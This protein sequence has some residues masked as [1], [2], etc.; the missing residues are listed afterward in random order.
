MRDP[1]VLAEVKETLALLVAK[2]PG[3]GV[4]VRVPPYAAVQCVG[5]PT[6]RRGT[7]P[8]VVEMDADTWLAL[9]DGRVSWEQ[10]VASGSVHASGLRTDL[11]AYLP[12][13]D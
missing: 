9:A 2:A 7:P 5:G 11:S 6:H 8:A 13:R 3:R 4:E 1:A 10:A 12:V